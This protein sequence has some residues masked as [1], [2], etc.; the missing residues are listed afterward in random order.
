MRKVISSLVSFA[1][2]RQAR[3]FP[4]LARPSSYPRKQGHKAVPAEGMAALVQS[5]PVASP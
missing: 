5:A 4:Q 3:R 1:A 2:S